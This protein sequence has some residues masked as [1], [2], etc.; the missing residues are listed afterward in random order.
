MGGFLVILQAAKR[1]PQQSCRDGLRISALPQIIIPT[2]QV[3]GARNGGVKQA[4]VPVAG[5]RKGGFCEIR[6]KNR[7][8]ERKRMV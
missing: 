4:H 7:C 6:T 1:A 3:R 8:V 5:K 2:F